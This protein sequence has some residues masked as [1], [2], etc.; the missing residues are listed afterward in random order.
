MQD[1]EFPMLL[2]FCVLW[3]L[4]YGQEPPLWVSDDPGLRN[5]L[6]FVAKCA[7]WCLVINLYVFGHAHGTDAQRA[8]TGGVFAATTLAWWRVMPVP[9]FNRRFYE[10]FAAA[11][12]ALMLFLIFSWVA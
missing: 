7:V 9:V 2:G 4:W 3:R 10:I 1:A 11:G 6:S 5:L 8:L 12:M